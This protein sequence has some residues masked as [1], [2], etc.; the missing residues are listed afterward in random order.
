MDEEHLQVRGRSSAQSSSAQRIDR[1]DRHVCVRVCVHAGAP[2]EF[3]A[4][5]PD[6]RMSGFL[7]TFLEACVVGVG[8]DRRDS[9][10]QYARSCPIAMLIDTTML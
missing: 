1:D 3:M 2:G 10:R 4:P 8:H 9:R 6:A 7:H 5:A